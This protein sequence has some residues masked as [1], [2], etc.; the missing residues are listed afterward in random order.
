MTDEGT[1]AAYEARIAQ[2]KAMAGPPE[3][4]M[5]AFADG[6]PAGGRVLDLG[7][8]PGTAAARLGALGLDVEGWDATP[9][10]VE[11][12]RAE[13]VAARVASFDDLADAPPEAFD[14][15]WAS[16]SL[17]HAPRADLP[18]HMSRI[19][20]ILRPGGLLH[21]GM[22]TG[23]GERRDDLGRFYAYWSVEE[24]RA[25]LAE[26]GLTVTDAREGAEAGL[27]GTVEPFVI[28]RAVKDDA[29]DRDGGA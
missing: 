8:G 6:L 1:I 18:R 28:M 27:A 9:A 25:L 15:V 4:D 11:A 3:E 12:A 2:Y 5:R 29:R 16:F 21:L 20:R 17:L 23:T 19:A 7:C 24:L 22:K 10:M 14:G 26:A 13:G